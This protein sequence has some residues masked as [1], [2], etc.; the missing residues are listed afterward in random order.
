MFC[1]VHIYHG[2]KSQ[3][4]LHLS[5]YLLACHENRE[6][7]SLVVLLRVPNYNDSNSP[8]THKCGTTHPAVDPLVTMNPKRSVSGSRLSSD[9][10]SDPELSS[11]PRFFWAGLDGLNILLKEKRRLLIMQHCV[12]HIHHIIHKADASQTCDSTMLLICRYISVHYVV[13]KHCLTG[14][15]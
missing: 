10:A 15:C 5:F 7:V 9:P 12:L 11:S 3:H 2:N 8:H 6:A 14:I 4:S 13:Q 1:D